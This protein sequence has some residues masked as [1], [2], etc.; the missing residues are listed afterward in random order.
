MA[1]CVARLIA[2]A[3]PWI[4][5]WTLVVIVAAG[6]SAGPPGWVLLAGLAATL[7]VSV[8]LLAWALNACGD[9]G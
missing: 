1:R 6:L 2:F 8:A 7:G 9:R 3:V 5:F 4:G